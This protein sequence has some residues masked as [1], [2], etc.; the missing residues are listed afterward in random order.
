[1]TG[2]PIRSMRLSA[3]SAGEAQ[4]LQTRNIKIAL[5]GRLTVERVY[6]LELERIADQNERGLNEWPLFDEITDSVVRTEM[7]LNHMDDPCSMLVR[8]IG[9]SMKLDKK[10]PVK[11]TAGLTKT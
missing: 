5:L 4:D 7:E 10:E 2:F 8:G 3:T 9:R 1:M 6:E 11:K